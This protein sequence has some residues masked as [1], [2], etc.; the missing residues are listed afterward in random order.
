[1][2]LRLRGKR[3]LVTGSSSGIGE[4]IAKTLAK[5][6]VF[7]VIHGRSEQR[8]RQV[9]DAIVQNGGQAAIAIGDLAQDESA[10]QAA[11]EASQAFGGIDILVNNAGGGGSIG[12]FDAPAQAWESAYAQNVLSTVRL[13]QHLAPPMK[14]AGWG[15]IINIASGVATQPTA[16]IPDYAAAKAAI[17]N[18]TVSLAKELAYTGITVNTISPG[19]ILTSGLENAVRGIATANG[20]NTDDWSELETRTAREIW[21]NPTGGVG[22]VEDVANLAAYLASPLASFVNGS[23][24]RIDGGNITAIN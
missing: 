4:A 10:A 12:W 16:A 1:M 11:K 21:P 3:A 24:Y 8:T 19:T 6:G 20:W 14:L 2:E 18:L 9:A 23:N 22:R 15:R 17:V 5:E 13:I 7:V